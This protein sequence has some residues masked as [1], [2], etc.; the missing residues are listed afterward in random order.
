MCPLPLP[1]ALQAQ[2]GEDIPD[3][4]KRYR[5]SIF[6]LDYKVKKIAKEKRGHKGEPQLP[7]RGSLSSQTGGLHA[8]RR[9][10]PAGGVGGERTQ[11]RQQPRP[12]RCHAPAG[13]CI[14][15]CQPLL[16]F[17]S[18]PTHSPHLRAPLSAGAALA[19]ADKAQVVRQLGVVTPANSIL[20][21]LGCS[22]EC[23]MEPQAGMCEM[24]T[25]EG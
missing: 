22:A 14:F 4:V 17:P 19:A 23:S 10:P 25:S 12:G 8:T 13:A 16:T 11:L 7:R 2:Q 18:T 6:K 1:A 24:E 9:Q 21:I 20:G 3:Q 15:C 5:Q